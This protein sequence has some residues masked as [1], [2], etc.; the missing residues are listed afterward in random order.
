M[1][2]LKGKTFYVPGTTN[3]GIFVHNEEVY[4]IDTGTNK[5]IIRNIFEEFEGNK[6]IVLNTHFHADHSQND[7]LAEKLGAKILVPKKE[8]SFFVSEEME[9]FYLYGARPVKCLRKGFFSIKTISP[10]FLENESLPMKV[11]DLK[12]HSPGM[13]GFLTSDDVLFSADVFFPSNIL[14]KYGYPYH[15]N[16]GDALIKMDEVLKMNF[17]IVVPSHGEP[18]VDPKE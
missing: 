2:E 13:V 11:V 12:G 15:S 1:K 3:I 14:K 9:G 8:Y 5:K 10:G 6:I 16:V 18:L 4:I 7:Y 17:E